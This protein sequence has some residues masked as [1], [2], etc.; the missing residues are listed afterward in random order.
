MYVI[1]IN[2]VFGSEKSVEWLVDDLEGFFVEILDGKSRF[3][4]RLEACCLLTMRNIFWRRLS[5][6][7]LYY[8][9]EILKNDR[10]R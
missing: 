6:K 4:P 3:N 7:H 5:E 2:F 10:I 8:R 9:P 1:K